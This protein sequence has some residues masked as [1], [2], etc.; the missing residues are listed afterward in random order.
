MAGLALRGIRAPI[1]AVASLVGFIGGACNGC[2]YER[3][4]IS[5]GLHGISALA[6]GAD[7]RRVILYFHGG[8]HW[9]LTADTYREFIGRL[10]AFTG[11]RVV[12]VEYRKPPAAQFPSGV[13]DALAAW[14]WAEASHPGASVA[15]AGD[16]S[17]ANLAFALLV[18]LA[19]L[20]QEQPV[21]CV[22]ISPWLRLDLSDTWDY[23]GR[24]CAHL[25]LGGRKDVSAADPLVSPVNA[26]PPLVRRFPPILMH[27][28]AH[29]MT[30][31]G[32]VEMEKVCADAGAP[33]EVHF[34]KAPHIFQV[35][36]GFP[37]QTRDSLTR[38]AE[39]LQRHW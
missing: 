38:I 3:V 20:G 16:S 33:A 34:Y 8:G 23:Y 18:Q 27:A 36:A 24:F 25:Y 7:C 29:E 30:T 26:Q 31:A 37:Q 15:V 13:F 35:T 10:S 2:A 28:G 19:Q 12:A 9:L 1:N 11:A 14:Q 39:F 22:G 32:V 17:G 5:E 4:E 21:A 6:P